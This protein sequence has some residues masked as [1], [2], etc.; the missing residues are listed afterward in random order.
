MMVLKALCADATLQLATEIEEGPQGGS[1]CR[2]RAP[3]C[4]R[5]ARIWR[6]THLRFL[7]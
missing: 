1:R 4:G 7:Q 3:S 6:R 5:R 2:T